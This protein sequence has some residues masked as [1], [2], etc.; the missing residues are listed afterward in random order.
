MFLIK[1]IFCLI[2]QR[3]SHVNKAFYQKCC[4]QRKVNCVCNIDND[5]LLSDTQY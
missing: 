1:A 4:D 2:Y 5:G 3:F